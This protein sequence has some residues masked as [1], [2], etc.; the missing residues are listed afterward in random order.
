[1]AVNIYTYKNLIFTKHAWFRLKERSITSD[2]IY[3]TL[4]YP[5]KKL[6]LNEQKIKFIKKLNQRQIQVIA[7]F[8]MQENKW[9]IISV[10]VRG[11]ADKIPLIWQIISLPFRLI[12]QLIKHSFFFLFHRKT[13]KTTKNI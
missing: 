3:Q 8:L 9:L 1:M 10:W 2:Q 11:E 4:Q 13:A 5:E 7:Q 6:T 12:F